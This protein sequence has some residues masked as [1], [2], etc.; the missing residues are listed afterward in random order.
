MPMTLWKQGATAIATELAALS[1]LDKTVSDERLLAYFGLHAIAAAVATG[2]GW[3]LMPASLRSA[4][5]S[6]LA[7]LYSFAFFIP[8][9]GVIATVVVIHV[10]ARFP[11]VVRAERFM[12]I[13]PPKFMTTEKETQTNSDIRAGYARRIL[14]DPKE[15]VDTKLRVLIALQD[16]RPK[17]AIPMLQGLLSDPA[18]D[19]RLLAYSMMDAWEK[20]ITQRLQAA[21]TQ[22]DQVAASGDGVGMFNANRRLAELYWEQ[23]DTKLARGDL[24]TFALQRAKQH[25]EAALEQDAKSSGI[26]VLFS[27][28]L[29]ELNMDDAAMK[30]LKIARNT[31]GNEDELLQ[32]AAQ[33]AYAQGQFRDVQ[34]VMK[35]LAERERVPHGWQQVVSFWTGTKVDVLV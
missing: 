22:L 12:E 20:D 32:L 30:T 8:G 27:R 31:G 26:W 29:I 4:P 7:L 6:A 13:V 5:K 2:M 23:V 3:L 11:K 15:S 28:V 16:M 21:Q 34:R 1:L 24:R 10:A 25:C 33:R 17:V 19:I 14:G 18:E 35:R 9:A